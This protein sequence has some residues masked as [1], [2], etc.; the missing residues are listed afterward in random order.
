MR[1]E[2][3]LRGRKRNGSSVYPEYVDGALGRRDLMR[4]LARLAAAPWRSHCPRTRDWRKSGR[5]QR[6]GHNSRERSAIEWKDVSFRG[7]AGQVQGLLASPRLYQSPPRGVETG[8]AGPQPAVLGSRESRADGA[9]SHVTRRVAKA[10]SCARDR[11]AVA[12][13][14]DEGLADDTA[15][16]SLRPPPYRPNFHEDMV[17]GVD[18]L[19]KQPNVVADRIGGIGSARRGNIYYSVYTG[20]RSRPRVHSMA[21]PPTRFRRRNA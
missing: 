4:R 15:P 8:V 19:K 9:Y 14:R 3:A 11:S 18:Y 12:A 17:S 20:C 5:R 6:R 7:Q 2:F 21:P 1:E 16:P 13:G 10:G